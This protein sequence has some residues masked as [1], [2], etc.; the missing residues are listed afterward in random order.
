VLSALE[1]HDS[2]LARVAM[3]EHLAAGAVPLIEHLIA[4]GVVADAAGGAE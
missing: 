4:R 2:E 3:A 1:A